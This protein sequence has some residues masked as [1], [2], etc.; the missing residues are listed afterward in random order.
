MS[1]E[2]RQLRLKIFEADS[3]GALETA[4]SEFLA[5]GGTDTTEAR[6]VDW[7]Y[8]VDSGTHYMTLIYAE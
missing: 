6:L 4:V 1:S 2:L 7:S 3:A 8:Q 5:E